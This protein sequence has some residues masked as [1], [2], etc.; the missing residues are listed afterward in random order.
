MLI[1]GGYNA[2]KMLVSNEDNEKTEAMRETER[3]RTE[4][5]REC[6]Q[7]LAPWTQLFPKPH[8]LMWFGFVN[9]KYF[10]FA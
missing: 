8:L 5:G 4:G 7:Q 3:Q 1:P 2:E 9:I 6:W 10:V